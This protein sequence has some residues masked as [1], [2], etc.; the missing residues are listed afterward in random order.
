MAPKYE[1][2]QRVWVLHPHVPRGMSKK[3]RAPWRGPFVIVKKVGELNYH[4]KHVGGRQVTNVHINKLKPYIEGLPLTLQEEDV[5]KA[6]SAQ[7]GPIPKADAGNGAVEKSAD[8]N[9]HEATQEKVVEK[10]ARGRKKKTEAPQAAAAQQPECPDEP[11]PHTDLSDTGDIDWE[12]KAIEDKKVRASDGAIMYKVR[13][14]TGEATWEP[15]DHLNCKDL[16]EK[17]EHD[18]SGRE[19]RRS[20]RMRQ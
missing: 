3:L 1:V 7:I 12:D 16:V 6:G 8:N 5:V 14:M 13:F 19:R 17:Y 10:K 15:E 2:G 18:N 11:P 4:V 9:E 20:N